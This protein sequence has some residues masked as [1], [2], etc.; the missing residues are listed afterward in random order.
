MKVIKTI[1]LIS[2][3]FL[4]LFTNAQ[5]VESDRLALFNLQK[6]VAIQG[7]DP[8]AYFTDKPTKGQSSIQ[9]KYKG[10]T[11]Y[12]K[13]QINKRAFIKTPNK[14]EPMYG[15]WC[16]YAMGL[17]KSD[18][19]SINPTTYKIIDDKLYLF[20]NK[21]GINT[22]NKWNKDEEKYKNNADKNWKL[23]IED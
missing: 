12:F 4:S 15:G 23:I 17:E 19:V 21:L 11:Y 2:I 10:I 14:Y 5:E 8:V 13:T 7:Y 20:Y 18:R 22:L 1:S 3:L 6:N 16:A 9:Y